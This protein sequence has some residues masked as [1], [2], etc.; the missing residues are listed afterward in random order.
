MFRSGLVRPGDPRG[1]SI[2][3]YSTIVPRINKV[4]KQIAQYMIQ[5]PASQA[6]KPRAYVPYIKGLMNYASAHEDFAA[7]LFQLV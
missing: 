5:S 6:H 4:K 3:L 7:Q 1:D 2:L